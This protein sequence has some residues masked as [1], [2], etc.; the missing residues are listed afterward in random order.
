VGWCRLDLYLLYGEHIA[1]R[2]LASYET[3]SNSVLPD[4]LMWDLWA[5]AR[6]H[7]QV[8]SWVPNYRDLG[9]ADLTAAKLRKR[10]TAWTHYLIEQATVPASQASDE[11][12]EY[13]PTTAGPEG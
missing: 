13:R 3:A 12:T 1:D 11:P 6:S 10:H 2:F 8:E 5:V 7:E 4:R 9:R